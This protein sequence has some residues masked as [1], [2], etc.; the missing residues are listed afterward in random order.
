M[1]QT[2]IDFL[3]A[4]YSPELE[5]L[6]KTSGAALNSTARQLHNGTIS[7]KFPNGRIVDISAVG[8]CRTSTLHSLEFPAYGG[9]GG[10]NYL[11]NRK[12]NLSFA[13]KVDR[14]IDTYLNHIAFLQKKVDEK[15]Q[16]FTLPFEYTTKFAK[17]RVY[18][19]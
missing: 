1:K 5:K 7:L 2:H 3:N 4:F 9:R 17:G 13:G 15:A 10:Y 18:G 6:L 11:L 12:R 14:G 16:L 8:Y 19:W